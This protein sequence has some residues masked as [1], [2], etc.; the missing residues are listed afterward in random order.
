MGDVEGKEKGAKKGR[1]LDE[2]GKRVGK[3]RS[4]VYQ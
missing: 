1:W 3:V 2:M 4:T